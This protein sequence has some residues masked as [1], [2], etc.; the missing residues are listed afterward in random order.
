MT[1]ITLRDWE[2]RVPEPNY[3]V[4]LTPPDIEPYRAGNTG[5]D[6]VTT[7]D[8]GVAGPHVLVTALTHGNED[9]RRDRARSIVPR[10]AAAATGQ[11]DFGVRQHRRLS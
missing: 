11:A 10:R 1:P 7:F 2:R 8:S 4:E 9:L 6:Y 3:A 5:I